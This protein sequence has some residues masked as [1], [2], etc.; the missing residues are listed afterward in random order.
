MCNK[1]TDRSPT[2]SKSSTNQSLVGLPLDDELGSNN[3][4][5]QSLPSLAAMYKGATTTQI[6]RSNHHSSSIMD[7]TP[8]PSSSRTKITNGPSNVAATTPAISPMTVVQY[9][10]TPSNSSNSLSGIA[11]HST[12]S[13]KGLKR[14]LFVI[15][16][17]SPTSG[18]KS[19]SS[20][21]INDRKFSI[22]YFIMIGFLVAI[23][24]VNCLFMVS[25]LDG[26]LDHDTSKVT[27]V[28]N[29]SADSLSM[30]RQRNLREATPLNLAHRRTLEEHIP[31]L[32]QAF[33]HV[34]T[35]STTSD[36]PYA[37][38]SNVIKRKSPAIPN[39]IT[40]VTQGHVTKFPRLAALVERWQGPVSCAMYIT[41]QEELF[42]WYNH[43]QILTK[44]NNTLFQ[45]Y[46]S[47]HLV[48]EAANTVS[49]PLYPINKLRNLALRNAKD[50][51]DYVFLDDIDLIP[52]TQSHSSV[53]STILREEQK[54]DNNIKEESS[55]SNKNIWVLPAFERF[56]SF[57][58]ESDTNEILAL[59]PNDKSSLN[60]ALANKDVAPFHAHIPHEHGHTDYARWYNETD[61]Y[62][63]EYGYN[64]EPYGIIPSKG[65]HEFFPMFRGFGKNKS[66]FFLEAH[67]RGYKFKILPNHFVV[68]LDHEF[69]DE[70]DV[71]N[72]GN[73]LQ[74][75]PEF[76]QYLEDEYGV[77]KSTTL[78]SEL[79]KTEY[80]HRDTDLR[81]TN[82][83]CHYLT[84]RDEEF[85]I[86]PHYNKQQHVNSLV[87]WLPMSPDDKY[88]ITIVTMMHPSDS[89][90]KRLKKMATNWSGQISVSVF[91]ETDDS[92]KT[93]MA[94]SKIKKFQSNNYASFGSRISF[95]LVTDLQPN[96]GKDVNVFPRNVLR[97]VALNHAQTDYIMVLD[98]DLAPSLNAHENMKNHLKRLGDDN[99][100]NAQSPVAIVVPAF[101][102]SMKGKKDEAV[103]TKPA[104][105][106]A[107]RN[108]PDLYRIF[109]KKDKVQ[110]HNAT[111]Y[112]KWYATQDL[113]YDVE[114]QVDYEP[115]VVVRKDSNLPPFWEHF[116]GFGRNKL[117]WV[118]ELYL[119]GFQF[120]V[121]PDSFVLHMNHK[122]YGLRRV[123][124][125][126]VDEYSYRFHAYLEEIYG[127][128]LQD[129]AELAKWGKHTYDKWEEVDEEEK[130][131]QVAWQQMDKMSSIRDV[132]FNSCL[133][134]MK[135]R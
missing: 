64:F 62:D 67:L 28:Y 110:A 77:P 72:N 56:P 39:S 26:H 34:T 94:K 135:A 13:L 92:S 87:K 40:L 79:L 35:S 1:N 115:Y 131:E 73:S 123:R 55:I 20:S 50:E 71:V 11:S 105:V 83:P 97:N 29:P 7:R 134:V 23:T 126:I 86:V 109:L 74:V 118:E 102:M 19:Y 5:A 3:S 15:N 101:E 93:S 125:F 76:Q 114:Y 88:D 49:K 98:M 9:P 63:V 21:I 59:I 69:L 16:T 4:S 33:E 75:F 66:T 8:S 104:L 133:N 85:K 117:Q 53:L 52:G 70:R 45:K 107:M 96:R 106:E 6:R 46:V 112:E 36:N 41:S 120:K 31:E 113:L 2:S 100:D 99:V 132:Q 38:I 42:S 78:E 14:K 37:E 27:D 54:N 82:F 12:V 103:T 91:I 108:Q 43:V 51:S 24:I 119:A 95:H 58:D 68:H 116:T 127:R 128:S 57:H 30:L 80:G 25:K 121:V 10:F 90:F 65:L 48:F 32:L 122:K 22:Y 89:M 47:I 44:G 124:P 129:A 61:I 60:L 130:T 17:Q 81:T 18:N 84:K 111:D